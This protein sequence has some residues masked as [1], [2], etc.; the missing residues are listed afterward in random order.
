MEVRII[1]RKRKKPE[2][3]LIKIYGAVIRRKGR[4]LA[5]LTDDIEFKEE[6]TNGS[7]RISFR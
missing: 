1:K 7:F 6:D 3:G 4:L 2:Y 5:E